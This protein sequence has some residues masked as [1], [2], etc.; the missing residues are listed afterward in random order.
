MYDDS[1]SIIKNSLFDCC[2]FLDLE[3]LSPKNASETPKKPQ[4]QKHIQ[5]VMPLLLAHICHVCANPRR[6]KNSAEISGQII[7]FHQPEFFVKSEDFPSL[8]T[9]WGEV[10]SFCFNYC[11]FLAG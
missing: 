4:Q 6:K 3:R 1:K 8:A 10:V 11:E 9:F 5:N 7:I 2:L